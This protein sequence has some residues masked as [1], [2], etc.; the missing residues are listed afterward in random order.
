MTFDRLND[1]WVRLDSSVPYLSAFWIHPFP[2]DAQEDHDSPIR[3]YRD[4]GIGAVQWVNVTRNAAAILKSD[5]G[6][7]EGGEF[8]LWISPG[9]GH[10]PYEVEFKNPI[11][12][13]AGD[14]DG[15]DARKRQATVLAES[16][17]GID[18]ALS[19]PPDRF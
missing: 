7:S 10:L 5:G 18:P 4:G 12:V 15:W 2:L 3:A 17:L 11:K 9:A 13:V 16:F 19:N 1:G 8:H 14:P 6:W